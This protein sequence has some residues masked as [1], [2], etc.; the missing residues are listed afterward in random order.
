MAFFEFNVALSGL[1]AAQRGLH[2]TSNNITNA[3]TD[4]YS[5][6]ILGQRADTPLSGFGVGMTGTGVMTTNVTRVRDS[7]LDLKL[8]T[9]NPKLGEYNIKVT[10]NSLIEGAFGEPSD[11]GFT[12]VF[13]DLFNSFDEVSKDP[14]S[15]AAKVSVRE[16]LISFGKYYSNISTALTGYQQNLNYEIKATVDEINI[17]G[18]RI[19]NL[20]SQIFQAEI[21]GDDANSFRDERDVCIDRLSELINV[22][23]KEEE[24]VVEGK[25]LKTFSVKIAGQTFVDHLNLN[26][27]GVEVRGE[28]EQKI[29]DIVNTLSG[30]YE[31]LNNGGLTVDEITKI[32]EQIKLEQKKLTDLT[33][34][35]TID[36]NGSITYNSP[37]EGKI[38]VLKVNPDFSTEIK[39]AGDGKFNVEDVDG[40]YNVI[41]QNGLSFD[42]GNANLSGELKGLIDLRDG[43]GTAESSEVTYNGIPYYISRLNGYV[44]QFAQTMNDEY[45]KDKDG[46]I[47]IAGGLTYG[48]KEV[49]YI[50]RDESGKIVKCYDEDKNE[51]AGLSAGEL[52]EIGNKYT[53]KYKLFSYSTGSSTGMPATGEDLVG[54]NYSKMTA[55]NITIS[56]EIYENAS[57]MR[58]T[59][60]A[61]EESGSDLFRALSNQKD[62]S[63]MFKEGDP[64]DYMASIFSE[65]GINAQEALMYQSTQES[66]TGIIKNQRL[67]VSQVDLTEE[68]TSLIKYQQAYQAS[69]KIMNTIDGIYETTIFKLGNF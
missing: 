21:Y 47:M 2:V 16:N 5:R 54:N 48:G 34:E 60:G 55:T 29:D 56:K 25:V 39:T 18:T 8:W 13:N 67:S 68:F 64:K 42:M 31:K 24:K 50:E 3:S 63:K 11:A 51:I 32:N 57:N 38:D 15:G 40:L 44:R 1:F 14:T 49:A 69:A 6:Q 4:G 20:N 66:V 7:Y 59:Y 61:D 45:S 36:A 43:C 30:L 41:W 46:T 35:C 52:E 12:K 37:L 33:P 17:L 9:Q 27:L 10:Q 19:Q 58:S 62:N 26:T 23:A 28:K 65:L 22:E 53:T